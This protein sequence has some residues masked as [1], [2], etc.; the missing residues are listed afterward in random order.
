MTVSRTLACYEASN[1][2]IGKVRPFFNNLLQEDTSNNRLAQIIDGCSDI[3]DTNLENKLIILS[4][5]VKGQKSNYLTVILSL[6]S[7]RYSALCVNNALEFHL[8]RQFVHLKGAETLQSR[9]EITQQLTFRIG[10]FRHI[11]LQQMNKYAQS[12]IIPFSSF[13]Q[14]RCHNPFPILLFSTPLSSVDYL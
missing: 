8:P 12:N 2:Q 14:H 11:F 7:S 1:T 4:R 9:T 5:Q 13:T 6:N 3:K 10:P